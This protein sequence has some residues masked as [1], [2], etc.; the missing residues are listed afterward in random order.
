MDELKKVFGKR[1]VKKFAEQDMGVVALQEPEQDK[2]TFEQEV[3][4]DCM[5]RIYISHAVCSRLDF[6]L[7]KQDI[8]E[9]I[10]KWD[11][12]GKRKMGSGLNI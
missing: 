9:G 5:R 3:E 11:L 2:Y 1:L 12:G 4:I 7:S 6:A 10:I 8:E